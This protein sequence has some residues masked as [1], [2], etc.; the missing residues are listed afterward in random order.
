MCGIQAGCPPGRGVWRN[1][2][3]A[4]RHA[5]RGPIGGPHPRAQ[6]GPPDMRQPS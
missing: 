5:S 1:A 6:A 3:V 4:N 2:P